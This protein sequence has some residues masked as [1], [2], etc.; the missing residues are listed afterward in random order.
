MTSSASPSS[1]GQTL[2]PTPKLQVPSALTEGPPIAEELY[3]SSVPKRLMKDGEHVSQGPERATFLE[4]L[5]TAFNIPFWLGCILLELLIGPTGAI[6]SFYVETRSLQES[7][8]RT[9]SLYFKRQISGLT[10]PVGLGILLIL[11]FYLLYTI[12]YMRLKLV[13]SKSLLAPILHG[14]EETY[15]KIFCR[16]SKPLPPI[17][18]NAILMT[19]YLLLVAPDVIK[20]YTESGT[21]FTNVTYLIV[22]YPI[23]LYIFS[24]FT[25]VYF[26]SLLGLYELSKGPLKTKPYYEDEMLGLRP[27]GSLTLSIASTY[28]IGLG[29]TALLPLVLSFDSS[30]SLVHIGL[31]F[32]LTLLGAV[33]FFLPLYTI[34]NKMVEVKNR[35]RESLRL[36][37]IK[38][39]ERQSEAQK[40]GSESPL[41]EMKDTLS[42]LTTALTFN[43][44]EEEV[45]K[46][47]TWPLDMPILSSA[48]TMILSITTIIL[49]NI[50][51]RK[52]LPVL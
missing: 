20:R 42:H 17:F 27:M 25:W 52:L 46:I 38:A 51:L 3:R 50:I 39:V 22:A 33:F 4:R 35:A 37:M 6:F 21:G 34:H 15:H 23:G 1:T 19:P 49:A 29:M 44:E 5:V 43:I 10:G 30:S 26:S 9:S 32:V 2:K 41:S 47:L 12:R 28:F 36:K 48:R 16:V 13:S 8:S 40:G 11:L 18:L 45:G 14:G 24:T 7:V 31:L